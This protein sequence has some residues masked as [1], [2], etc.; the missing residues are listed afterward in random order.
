MKVAV[1]YIEWLQEERAKIN[2]V[3]LEEIEFYKNGMKLDFSKEFLDDFSF[4]GLNNTDFVITGCYKD[5]E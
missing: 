2:R 1:E 5:P 4:T 3:A